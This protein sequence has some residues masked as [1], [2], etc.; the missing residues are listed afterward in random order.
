MKLSTDRLQRYPSVFVS[1]GAPSRALSPGELGASLSH[2]ARQL[3]PP[4]AILVV[5]AHWETTITSIATAP[6][7]KTMH[8]FYGFEDAL[9]RMRY[10]APV[11]FDLVAEVEHLL[12][13][14]DIEF[15]ED[16][17]RGWDHG[18]WV[19]LTW[20]VPSAD[21]PVLALSLKLRGGAAYHFQ[22][23]QALSPLLDSGVLLMGSGNLTHNL[24]D[25]RRGMQSDTPLPYVMEFREWMSDKLSAGDVA[26][27][28]DY[29]L[30]APG[31]QQSHPTDEH[32]M[33]LF[34]ALGAAAPSYV[35]QLLYSGVDYNVL[36]MDSYAFWKK[37]FEV[38]FNP[39]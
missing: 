6:D 8:D 4:R 11:A 9:Y 19:P 10:N 32:L 27:L 5:S 39:H 12:R 28:L 34:V 1:H 15:N 16:G 29:A 35:S 21:I 7:S 31:A 26:S 13:H 22:L 25:I 3:S 38:T 37:P 23:G 20:M 18:V 33:P 17:Q 30:Q 24:A 2:L 36:A 14:A